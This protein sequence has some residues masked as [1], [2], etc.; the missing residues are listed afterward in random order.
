MS[1]SKTIFTFIVTAILGAFTFF[2][3]TSKNGLKEK[4]NSLNL[5]KKSQDGENM[6]V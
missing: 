3:A 1:I 5:G 6:F 2:I 4:L